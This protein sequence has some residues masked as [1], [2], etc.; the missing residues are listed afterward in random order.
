MNFSLATIDAAGK[1]LMGILR[2]YGGGEEKGGEMKAGRHCPSG[3]MGSPTTLWC[4]PRVIGSTACHTEEH[5]NE[6]VGENYF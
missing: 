2:G 6:K 5:L 4:R 3:R 1:C